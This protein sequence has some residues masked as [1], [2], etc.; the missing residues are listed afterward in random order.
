MNYIDEASGNTMYHEI[1]YYLSQHPAD[2]SL[3]HTKIFSLSMINR[4]III[5]NLIMKLLLSLYSFVPQTLQCFWH[6]SF[7][8]LPLLFQIVWTT[9]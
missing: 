1:A 3:F 5:L 9:Q 6:E 4:F 8:C 7:E 2:F